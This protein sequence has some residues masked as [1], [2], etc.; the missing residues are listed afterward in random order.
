MI[1]TLIFNELSR[2][3]EKESNFTQQTY[4]LQAIY[5]SKNDII[6]NNTMKTK[7]LVGSLVALSLLASTAGIAFAAPFFTPVGGS[8]DKWEI[9]HYEYHNGKLTLILAYHDR[10]GNTLKWR[11]YDLSDLSDHAAAARNM[12]L[13]GNFAEDTDASSLAKKAREDARLSS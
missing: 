7:K 11:K 4:Q 5:K 3:A 8:K 10:A 9:Y 6:K 13:I 1:L 2:F 12:E